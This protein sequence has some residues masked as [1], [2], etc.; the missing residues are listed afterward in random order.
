MQVY[1]R[2]STILDRLIYYQTLLY[3]SSIIVVW[4][5]PTVAPPIIPASHLL[6]VPIQIL[7][8]PRNSMNNRFLPFPSQKTSCTIAM[9]DDWDFSHAKIIRAIRIWQT[10]AF[11]RLVGFR[12]QARIHIRRPQHTPAISTTLMA[13]KVSGI[14][15]TAVHAKTSVLSQ[16]AYVKLVHGAASILM[17]SATVY[18]VQYHHMY[19]HRLPSAARAVI[20]ELTNCDDILFNMMVANAT[21]AGPVVLEDGG[22]V[23]KALVFEGDGKGLWK[24]NEHWAKRGWCMNYFAENIFFGMPLKVEKIGEFDRLL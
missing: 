13:L 7:I 6:P 1:S 14:S 11:S 8:Q 20:D 16:Y 10:R 5:N 12:Q 17:P 18:H 3:L 15:P 23:E 22:K 4:N 19:T 24:D 21:G 9:D 2:T